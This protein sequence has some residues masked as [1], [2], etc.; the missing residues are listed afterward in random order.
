MISRKSI[1]Y[2]TILSVALSATLIPMTVIAQEIYTIDDVIPGGTIYAQKAPQGLERPVVVNEGIL[3]KVDDRWVLISPGG[4][5]T[6]FMTLEEW[7]VASGST[8]DKLPILKVDRATNYLIASQRSADG[9]YHVWFLDPG[10]KKVTSHF[11]IRKEFEA[12][13][14]SVRSNRIA[15][16]D[17][18][19]LYMLE[20]DG[21]LKRLTFD[22]SEDIVYGMPAH[23]NEFGISQGTFW[24][25]GGRYLALYKIDQSAV[26]SYPLVS[27]ED[28]IAVHRPIK[29]PMAGRPSQKVTIGVYDTKT[30]YIRYLDTGEPLDRYFT[31]I[32]WS[33]DEKHIYIDEV[34]RNQK[35]T[36]LT[37]YDARSGK[38]GSTI[39]TETNDK[40]IEPQE[41]IQFVPGRED[42]LIRRSRV[43]GFDH[44]Y[45]YSNTGK[46]AKQLTN[47]FWEV[48]S[49]LG[50]DPKGQWV[51]FTANREDPRRVDLYRVGVRGG[52]IE[53]ITSGEGSHAVTLSPDFKLAFDSYSGLN[54]PLVQK[55]IPLTRSQ[56]AMLLRSESRDTSKMPEVRLGTIKS[57]DGSADLYYKM[58]LPRDLDT[59]KKYPTIIYV[60]G[61]PHAQLVVDSWKGLRQN[62]DNYMAQRGYIVFTI[63]GR[64]S[65]HRGMDFESATFKQLGKCELEDQMAGVSYL[66]T[67]PYV[68]ADRIGVHGWSFGGF[69]TTLMMLEHPEVFK[70]GV[71][72][73]PVM[74]WKYYEV[75]YGERYMETPQTNPQGYEASDLISRAGTL[76]GRL[77]LIHGDMDPVVVWQHSLSFLRE[78]QKSRK[79]P[80]YMVYPGHEHN[81]IGKDR[82]QLYMYIT[83][84]F[85]EHLK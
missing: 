21:Q 59:R 25:P 69:M 56:S 52:S 28:P 81:V 40:Y 24:S 55:M 33:P 65:A 54:T 31:N 2:R 71:A 61:G 36:G 45:C 70:V 60:Y 18:K 74:N 62:W 41:P 15:L 85:D 39:I 77:L 47:G 6:S 26:S 58:T 30:Q 72:G 23:R 43:N 76:Q 4:K 7:K 66:K 32:A 38:P 16:M 5:E 57:A 34:D 49:L 50:I 29:Y 8:V 83:R 53:R 22:G 73:G 84:Y 78:A 1:L 11:E 9:V 80:D 44:L 20:A 12:L 13:D 67:L 14:P 75:M 35:R 63:D 42:L 46:L 68:D 3:H 64:G 10:S 37:R 79:M 17:G 82:P 19:D 27:I 51:Y 48:R